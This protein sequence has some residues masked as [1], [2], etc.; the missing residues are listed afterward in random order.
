[1]TPRATE[2]SVAAAALARR[3]P[4]R[5]MTLLEIAVILL[6]VGLLAGAVLGGRELMDASRVRTL[7]A[8]INGARTAYFGFIDRYRSLP[9]DFA[10]ATVSIPNATANGNGNGRIEMLAAGAPV[11]E[12]IAAWEHLSRAGYLIG[13]FTYSPGPET[14]GN[15]PSSAFGAF[16]RVIHGADFAGEASPR[17]NLNTGNFIPARVLA[18]ADRKADDGLAAT[19]A[20]RF[21]SVATSGNA[22][23]LNLCVHTDG[24]TAGAWRVTGPGDNGNCGATWLLE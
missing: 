6:I 14:P 18:E 17:S 3:A 1:M 22:P 7:L 19:G 21:S 24:S 2:P 12:H 23:Q 8:E 11:D 13:P 15:A 9:G 4:N 16:L 20:F 5:G 10:G